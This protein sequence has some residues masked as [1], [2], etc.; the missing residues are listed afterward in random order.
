VKKTLSIA[1]TTISLF[2][3]SNSVFAQ[4]DGGFQIGIAGGALSGAS[5]HAGYRFSSDT[6]WLANRFGV[7]VEYSTLAPIESIIENL[8]IEVEE[9]TFTAFA[10]GQQYGALLDF[11]PFGG[12]WG[13]GNFRISGGYY[14]GK[15]E[16]GAE[17]SENFTSSTNGTFEF[18]GSTYEVNG[19]ATLTGSLKSK[20]TG[21]YL[22]LG[23]DIALLYGLKL[24]ADVGVVFTDE[25]EIK[26]AVSG[27]ADIDCTGSTCFAGIG[28]GTTIDLS[29]LTPAVQA[30]L[31]GFLKDMQSQFDD[32][33][34]MVKQPYYP[35][36]KIGL[37]Y[38][39]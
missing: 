6:S 1:I 34:E 21:P 17:T 24:F 2:T 18:N 29:A 36:A 30:E 27:T 28:G 39:F 10:K 16:F 14:G 32:E 35:M 37:L 15:F 38:R 12:T 3:I 11:Y 31:D 7:R 33:L 19:Q 9:Q 13:L 5:I 23:F 26:T 4:T 8:E 20:A 22:G 25:P